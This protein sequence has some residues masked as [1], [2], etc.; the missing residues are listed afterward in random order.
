LKVIGLVLSIAYRKK[1]FLQLFF[2]E[3]IKVGLG[4]S[5]AKIGEVKWFVEMEGKEKQ[6]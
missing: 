3:V 5:P 4:K 2:L 6:Q 1:H